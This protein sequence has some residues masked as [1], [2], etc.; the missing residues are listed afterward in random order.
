MK[1]RHVV[2]TLRPIF[3]LFQKRLPTFSLP[4]LFPLVQIYCPQMVKNGR[5]Y[6]EM[7]HWKSTQAL[8]VDTDLLHLSIGVEG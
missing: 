8:G 4:Q 1:K 2:I 6:P 5:H 3:K 7:L